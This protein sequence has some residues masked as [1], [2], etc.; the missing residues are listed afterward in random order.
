[1]VILLD[2]LDLPEKEH[3]DGVLPRYDSDR[4]VGGA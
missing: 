4:L 3:A 2:Y 1:M